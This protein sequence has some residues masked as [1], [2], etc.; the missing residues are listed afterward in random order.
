M[1]NIMTKPPKM[2]N[3]VKTG[4]IIKHGQNC[5]KWPKPSKMIKIIKNGRKMTKHVKNEGNGQK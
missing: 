3:I 4:Q 5:T 2:I 1:G